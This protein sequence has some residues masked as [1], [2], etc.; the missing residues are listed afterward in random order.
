MGVCGDLLGDME[1]RVMQEVLIH[2]GALSLSF[3][4]FYCYNKTV[5]A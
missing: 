5:G 1:M 3:A 2:I 4:P